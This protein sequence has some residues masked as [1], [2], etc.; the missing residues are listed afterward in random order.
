M[1]RSCSGWPRWWS[2][3]GPWST[4]RPLLWSNSLPHRSRLQKSG[5]RTTAPGKP[6]G[7]S[8]WIR[9]SRS[10]SERLP[11]FL[12]QDKLH[13]FVLAPLALVSGDLQLSDLAGVGDVS[14]AV[15]LGVYPLYL[16]DAHRS[17]P[18]RNQV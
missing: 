13:P 16:Y 14:T 15:G 4:E 7:F 9:S 11:E 18:L 8:F 3:P 10:A 5:R 12:P 1:P 17:H 6:P 2:A